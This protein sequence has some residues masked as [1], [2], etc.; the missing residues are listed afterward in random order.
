MILLFV[1]VAGMAVNWIHLGFMSQ[2]FTW[3]L[4][5]A[6]LAAGALI[7]DVR[8]LQNYGAVVQV[9]AALIAVAAVFV[10]SGVP[11]GLLA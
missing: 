4:A 11:L 9:F 10:F 8:K 1:A 5:V 7:S 6:L 3:N 2:G